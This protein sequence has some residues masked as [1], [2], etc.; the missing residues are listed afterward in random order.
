MSDTVPAEPE[1][2][3]ALS[4]AAYD[5][6]KWVALVGLP[7]VGTLYFSLADIW[8]LPAAAQVVGTIMAV[9]TFLGLVLGLAKKSYDNSDAKYDATLKIDAQDN[10]LVHRL[11]IATPPEEIG[12]KKDLVV[13]VEQV[14]PE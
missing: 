13:K 3:P 5:R 4:N 14:S 1:K 7:A 2:K 10:R 8:N 11:E 9:D 6:A 12:L